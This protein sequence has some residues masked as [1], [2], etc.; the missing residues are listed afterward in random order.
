M[1]IFIF[2][3]LLSLSFAFISPDIVSAENIVPCNGVGDGP[4]GAC[5]TCHFVQLGNN[6]VRWLVGAMA[7]IATVA[8]VIG[9]LNMVTAGGD[10]GKISHGKELIQN[11]LIGFV[12]LLAA[13]LI[14]DTVMKTLVGNGNTVPGFG[15][16]HTIQCVTQPAVTPPTGPGGTVGVVPGACTIADMTPITEPAAMQMEGGATLVW[17]NPALQACAQKFTGLVGGSVTSAYRP[18]AYQTHLREL[19]DKWCAGGLS[20]NT[21]TECSAVKSSIGS[22]MARHGLSCARPVGVTSN[23]SSGNAIDISTNV[24]HGSQAVRDAAAASCLTWPL[25]ASDPV[26]YEYRAGCTCN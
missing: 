12:I 11:A 10:T 2:L 5:Q 13:W 24:A 23:H 16:W 15:P 14:I 1:R 8:V 7:A 9:G 17:N 4:D 19:H 3:A 22:E 21:A 26:H 6:L 20:T 25:G 18:P